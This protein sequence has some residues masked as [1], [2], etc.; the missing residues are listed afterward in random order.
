MKR[1]LLLIGFMMSVASCGG[2][3]G[4][5]MA[6]L[7]VSGTVFIDEEPSAGIEVHLY[8]LFDNNCFSAFLGLGS[9]SEV[10]ARD[11]TAVDGRYHIEAYG[12]HAWSCAEPKYVIAGVV[13]A[14][15]QEVSGCGEPTV[16]FHLTE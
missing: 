5:Q 10:I 15:S 11:T 12:G 6:D 4:P 13:G 7:V 9:C 2:P 1:S 3:T 14:V 8:R 16:D